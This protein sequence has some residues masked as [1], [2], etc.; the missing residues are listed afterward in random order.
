MGRAQVL[1]N[2]L[3]FGP[4]AAYDGA[5]ANEGAGYLAFDV[6]LVFSTEAFL[7]AHVSPLPL[8]G[9]PLCL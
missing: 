3:L 7:S 1:L 9:G 6:I 4:A 8:C 2:A 5:L